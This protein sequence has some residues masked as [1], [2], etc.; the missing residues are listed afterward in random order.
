MTRADWL[1]ALGF[2][3]GALAAWVWGLSPALIAFCGVACV[4]WVLVRRDAAP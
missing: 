4:G 3:L 1:P 2:A